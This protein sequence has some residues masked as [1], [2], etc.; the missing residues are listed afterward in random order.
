MARGAALAAAIVVSLL[1]VSGAGGAGAQ[2]PKR[3][4]TVVIAGPAFEPSCLNPLVESCGIPGPLDLGL[5]EVLAGAFTVTPNGTFRTNLISRAE[6]VSRQPFTLVYHIRSEAHWSDGV[7]LTASDFV[8]TRQMIRKQHLVFDLVNNVRSV[9]KLDA[10]TFRVVLRAPFSDWRLLFDLV[11][12]RH[13][14]AGEDVEGIWRDTIDNPRTGERI[15]SGPFL[16]GS[17]E[18]GRQLTLVRNPRYWGPHTANVDRIVLRFLPAGEDAA[19]ALRRGEV[20]MINPSSRVL[21]SAALDL[22][23]QREPGIR[24]LRVA[25][26]STEH[27]DIRIGSGGHPALKS[28]L[29]RQALA[30][31][32]DRVE[33]ARTIGK[34]FLE[35]EAAL[36]PLD[37]VVFLGNSPYYEPSWKGYRYRPARARRLL[38][39]A[40]CHRGPDGIYSCGG[41]RLSLRF[42]TNAGI[43]YREGVIELAQRELRQAGVEVRPVY[44][45]TLDALITAL[46]RGEFD[47]ALFSWNLGASTVPSPIFECQAPNNFTGYCDR[48]VTRDLVQATRMIDDNRRVRQLTRIDARL[49]KGVP[50]IPLFQNKSLFAFRA[51]IRGI[52]PNGVGL[53]TWNAE[54]W[55]LER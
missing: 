23:R 7:P 10:K 48:L 27:F 3:G 31:G 15:G 16:I 21:Q 39:Q 43:E 28:R 2:T 19:E 47:L 9:R 54:N 51:S 45:A 46:E 38:E 26:S 1:A 44:L 41:S 35:S 40:G 20:D 17:W 55:W 25:S 14:L 33:I 32:I 30:Y 13:A 22:L 49:A 34:L 37:S 18:R 5:S 53:F 42:M 50:V 6:I 24:V 29:V 12:P 4:G 8:F 52:V 11:L 36:A